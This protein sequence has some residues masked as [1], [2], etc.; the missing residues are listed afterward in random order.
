MPGASG[1]LA[2]LEFRASPARDWLLWMI[3]NP[4]QL[5][6]ADSVEM[7]VETAKL[8]RVL[9]QDDP[10]GAR[11]AAQERARELALTSSPNVPAWWRLEEIAPLDCVLTTNRLV[12]VVEG[13]PLG[14]LAPV[15]PWYPARTPVVRALEA[16]RKL[17]DDG[18]R[19]CSLVLADTVG[20]E[21]SRD[22]VAASLPAAAPH[23]DAE[24]R[25][26]MAAAYLGAL[27]WDAARAAVSS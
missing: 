14:E 3:A 8:R 12:I 23:L 21:A 6:W 27:T 24:G 10:P 19:W 5:T 4:H 17:A 11:I 25:A 9:F 1:R 20:P 16:A 13:R 26:A 7:T 18:R 15:T 22:A 2:C